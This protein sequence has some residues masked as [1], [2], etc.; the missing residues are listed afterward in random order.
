MRQ[1][2]VRRIEWRSF[3]IDKVLRR[4]GKSVTTDLDRNE[5]VMINRYLIGEI[6]LRRLVRAVFLSPDPANWRQRIAR[7]RWLHKLRL[8]LRQRRQA[9]AKSA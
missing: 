9:T 7:L 5:W 4:F 1:G 2:D 8:S 3:Y 6:P